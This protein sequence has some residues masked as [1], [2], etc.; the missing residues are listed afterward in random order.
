MT[1]SLV[2]Q[3]AQTL[4]L[5][6]ASSGA[7]LSWRGGTTK[8]G[9]D[10]LPNPLPVIVLAASAE[11]VYYAG[12]FVEGKAAA[13][14]CYSFDGEKPHPQAKN[15]GAADC[16][17]CPLNEFGSATNG[18]GK[19]CK[20][21]ARIALLHGDVLKKPEKITEADIVQARFS[22]SAAMAW[23]A[24]VEAELDGHDLPTWCFGISIKNEN[25]PKTQYKL[26]FSATQITNDKIL[27]LIAARVPAAERLV[28][29]PYATI[30]EDKPKPG[31]RARKF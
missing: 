21:G 22:V 27:D 13:P 30:A 24:F 8:L 18:K 14:E 16:A 20:E 23:R 19:A 28:T 4:K 29:T 6:S 11:R 1:K 5:P 10:K 25:D 15:K 2:T 31:A 3:R 26:S 17:N 12:A 7:F 9:D